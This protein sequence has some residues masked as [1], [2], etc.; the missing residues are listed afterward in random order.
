MTMTC[1]YMFR[2]TCTNIDTWRFYNHRAHTPISKNVVIIT[3]WYAILPTHGNL[4]QFRNYCLIYLGIARE[5]CGVYKISE[6]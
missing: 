2:P 5:W 3:V 4:F 1:G 6:P